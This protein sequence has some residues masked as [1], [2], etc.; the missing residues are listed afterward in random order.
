M[1]GRVSNAEGIK[2]TV[3]VSK[4]QLTFQREVSFREGGLASDCLTLLGEW[5]ARN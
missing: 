5:E 4:R 1:G 3:T 2:M